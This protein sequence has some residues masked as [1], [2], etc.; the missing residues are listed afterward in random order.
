M[1]RSNFPHRKSDR[2]QEAIVR[3]NAYDAL[4]IDQKLAKL[5]DMKAEKQRRKLKPIS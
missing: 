4:T 2:H 3:Q 1:L 5:G